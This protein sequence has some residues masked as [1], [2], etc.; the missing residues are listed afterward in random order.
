MVLRE[1]GLSYET[2]W[3]SAIDLRAGKHREPEFTKYNPN[4]RIPVLIDHSY[5]DFVVWWVFENWSRI[6][7]LILFCSRESDAILYYLVE[8]YDTEHKISA[9]TFDDRIMQQQ[10]LFFQASGQ[11]YVR[12]ACQKLRD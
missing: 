8:K 1:L 5:N 10:W 11:G 6:R 9:E 4:G 3:L 2:K 12:S 7:T